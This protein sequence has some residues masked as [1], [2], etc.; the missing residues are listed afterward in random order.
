MNLYKTKDFYFSCVLLSNNFKLIKSERDSE[1]NTVFFFF[2]I[3]KQENKKNELMDAYV[4]QTCLVNVKPFTWA[5]KV[6][7]NEIYGGNKL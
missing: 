1:K 2:D 6:L 4:N 3:T 7:K 5:I